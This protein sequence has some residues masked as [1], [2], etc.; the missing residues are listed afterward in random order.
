MRLSLFLNKS[1]R[2][3]DIWALLFPNSQLAVSW[4]GREKTTASRILTSGY[5]GISCSSRGL[6]RASLASDGGYGEWVD[7]DAWIP[8]HAVGSQGSTRPLIEGNMPV[9]S[10]FSGIPRALEMISREERPMLTT[11][12]WEVKKLEG[13]VGLITWI[14][15]STWSEAE[16]EYFGL[17]SGIGRGFGAFQNEAFWMNELNKKRREEE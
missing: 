10:K 3:T 16:P 13:Q 9:I 2:Y 5:E 4:L 8:V 12:G 7:G 1:Y 6:Q 14:P 11:R 15:E 17:S